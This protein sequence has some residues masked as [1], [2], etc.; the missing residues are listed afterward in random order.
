M[1]YSVV[2]YLIHKCMSVFFFLRLLF[3][4]LQRF[5]RRWYTTNS[6]KNRQIRLKKLPF[7]LGVII[8]E[9]H[10]AINDIASLINWCLCIGI[11]H[12]SIYDEPGE[13]FFF[14]PFV[15]FLIISW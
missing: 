6:N 9:D 7:H 2:L 4:E 10:L 11:H 14:L 1:F 13:R 8:N 3:K 15:N 12:I 5:I